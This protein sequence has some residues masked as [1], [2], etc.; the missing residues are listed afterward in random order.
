M[1]STNE[2]KLRDYLKRATT[3]L[4]QASWR[5]GPRSRSRSSR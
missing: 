4:R 1:A 2:D 5:A 3:D